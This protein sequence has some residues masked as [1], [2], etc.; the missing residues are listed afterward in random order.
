MSVVMSVWNGEKYL[1][2]AIE[3]VLGQAFRDLEFIIVNDRSTDGSPTIIA[4]CAKKDP[5]IVVINNEKDAAESNTN[6]TRSLN[7]ALA[8]VR[9]EYVARMDDD[10]VSLPERFNKQV[11]FLDEHPDVGLV[12]CYAQVIDENG[13]QL[14]EI[15]RPAGDLDDLKREL[16]FSNQITHSSIMI[17]KS[18]LDAVGGYD[19]TIR[20]AQDY[21]LYF[22]ILKIAKIAA[23]SEVLLLWRDRKGSISATKQR[24]QAHYARIAQ[25]RAIAAGLYPK[26]YILFLPLFFFKSLIPMKWKRFIKN[27]LLKGRRVETESSNN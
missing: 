21:D 13:D 17:R 19:K 18:A 16:F 20:R 24:E 22:R 27:L 8:A 1:R 25:K 5:R 12:S 15:K 10:D 4:E 7:R 9:G 14:N 11:R 26:W 23:V 2:Q 3:S 6:L